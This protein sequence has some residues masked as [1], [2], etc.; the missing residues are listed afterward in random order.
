MKQ[1]DIYW[2]QLNPTKGSEQKGQRPV[3]I[4]SGNAMN[5]NLG[6]VIACPFST[7]LKNYPGSVLIEKSKQN[8]LSK[9]SEVITF[10]IRSL[11]KSRLTQKLGSICPSELKR[12]IRALNEVLFY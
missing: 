6:M 10:Q 7:S 3:L 12:V 2:A 8:G 5:D 1:G 11:S 9:D 4:I